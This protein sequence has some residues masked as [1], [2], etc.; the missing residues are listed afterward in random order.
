M[1]RG[2]SLRGLCGIKPVRMLD[3]EVRLIRPM[4]KVCRQ[5]IVRYA[6]AAGL[7]WRHDHTNDEYEYTR[8]KIRHLILPMLQKNSKDNLANLITRL[9]EKARRLDERVAKQAE[10]IWGKAVKNT[11]SKK[12]FIVLNHSELKE[13]DKLLCGEILRFI[14]RQLD[15][16]QGRL[17]ERHYRSFFEIIAK[18]KGYINL[19]EDVSVRCSGDEIIISKIST[20][21]S[22]NAEQKELKF[23]D[24]IK[25]A[26]WLIE[27]ETL[28]AAQTD[29]ADFIK[30][31]NRFIEWFDAAKVKT[32]ILVRNRKA[33]DR[34][35]PIG[36]DDSKRVGKFLSS[37]KIDY[38]LKASAII[39][40]DAEKILWVVPIRASELAKVDSRTKRILQ[41]KVKPL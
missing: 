13:T 21:A 12:D 27:T 41:I 26:D 33:G 17:T 28:N 34:F 9:S 1:L 15:C 20:T 4:L 14:L 36:R 24:K 18:S 23:N 22:Q 5:E 25:F 6:E 39:I 7:K 11:S 35:V 29:L 2:C 32:P 38:A 10:V 37:E 3:A 16:G 30:N 19:P 8:N 31:K 40:T